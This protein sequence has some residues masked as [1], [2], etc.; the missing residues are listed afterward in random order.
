MLFNIST[1]GLNY[2]AKRYKLTDRVLKL[3]QSICNTQETHLRNEDRQYFSLKCSEN[4][5]QAKND[6]KQD[7]VGIL[8]SNKVDFHQK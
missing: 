2:Q 3:D 8:L 4:V 6:K 1:N 7:V 5:F